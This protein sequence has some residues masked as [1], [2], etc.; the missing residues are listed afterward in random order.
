M[1]RSKTDEFCHFFKAT[2]IISK[3][4]TGINFSTMCLN[5]CIILVVFFYISDQPC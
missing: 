5:Y 1:L 3:Y 2:E 4:L